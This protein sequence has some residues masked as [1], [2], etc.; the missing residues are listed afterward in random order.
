MMSALSNGFIFEV[1]VSAR[2]RLT[3]GFSSYNE[4]ESGKEI[5]EAEKEENDD[6]DDDDDNE[7]VRQV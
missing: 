4:R 5:E 1:S 6:D 3:V 7:E 2:E